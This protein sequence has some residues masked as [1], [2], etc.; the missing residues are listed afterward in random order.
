MPEILTKVLNLCIYIQR[1]CQIKSLP[2]S[3]PTHIHNTLIHEKVKEI[4]APEL[5]G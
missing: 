2:E 1:G 3:Y 4:N 5:V